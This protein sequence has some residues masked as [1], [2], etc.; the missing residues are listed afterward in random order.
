MMRREY[1]KA[2]ALAA[3]AS[4]FPLAGCI[5]DGQADPG[6]NPEQPTLDVEPDY[7]GWFE[8]VGNYRKTIDART[9]D[10]V[11]ITVGSSANGGFLGFSPAAV[12][13]SP[14]TTVT[15]RW[16]GKGG[17]HNVHAKT[18]AF[19]SGYS[20]EAGHTYSF[21]FEEPRIYPYQCDPH[22][23]MGMKGAVVVALE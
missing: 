10:A 2:A 5:Q 16:S 3:V 20:D 15:W 22:A 18:D 9:T 17:A 23:M 6:S 21:T 11:T 4:T 19:D 7:Q 12:A 8:G 1:L 14:G 13:V